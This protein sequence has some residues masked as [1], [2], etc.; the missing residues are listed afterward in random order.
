MLTINAIKRD[1]SIDKDQLRQE[2]KVPA[3]F[4]G[5]KEENT[6]IT[7]NEGELLKVY[8][9]AG[10]SS[11]II[12]KEGDKEHEALIY[13]IQWNAV[14]GRPMHIDFYV[15]EKGKKIQVSVPVEFVGE[16]PAVKTMGGI[17]MKVMHEIEI[18]ALPKDLPQDIKADISSL[19]NFDSKI[20][21]GD[22]VMP[23]GVTLISDKEE[24]IALV[25][26]VKEVVEEAPMDL[27]SIEVEKKGKEEPVEGEAEAK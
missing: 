7:I 4:Y 22:V 25:Q 20:T 12:L 27:S 17:L 21:A 11:V 2:G 23:A 13:D 6:P 19:V 16:S 3:V 26:E 14:S 1:L 24:F 9:E 18:E 5:P 10:E 15:I 8:N